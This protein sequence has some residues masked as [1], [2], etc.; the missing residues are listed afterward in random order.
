MFTFV[1]FCLLTYTDLP[2][3]PLHMAESEPELAGH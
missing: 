2:I 3:V 1:Y